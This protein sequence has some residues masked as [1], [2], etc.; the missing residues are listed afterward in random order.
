[1][2]QADEAELAAKFEAGE[3]VVRRSERGR[4][5]SIII[6]QEGKTL[7]ASARAFVPL[8]L[9]LSGE[10]GSRSNSADI[11]MSIMRVDGRRI[12]NRRLSDG[13]GNLLAQGPFSVSIDFDPL[14]L[15]A[16]L[17]R[18]DVAITD[19]HGDVDAAS[20]VLEIID[21]EGQFGGL[22]LLYYPP[23]IVASRVGEV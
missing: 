23:I 18:F 2:E 17:Y 5:S 6:E 11:R 19:E 21:E 10:I 16:G 7:T 1:V 15:G 22:P 3:T 4:L 9:V 8:R 14:I 20:R 13:S 12:S